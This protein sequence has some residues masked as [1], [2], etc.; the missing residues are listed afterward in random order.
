MLTIAQTKTQEIPTDRSVLDFD[1]VPQGLICS[2]F[3]EF[4]FT[5]KSRRS[6]PRPNIAILIEVCFTDKM[7]FV[8]HHPKADHAN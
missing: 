4:T 3:Q 2:Y 7:V 8:C 1:I 5:E 6:P